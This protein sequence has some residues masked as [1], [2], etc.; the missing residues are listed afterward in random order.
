MSNTID[1]K[2]LPDTPPATGP[3]PG[4][5]YFQVNHAVVRVAKTSDK[6]YLNVRYKLWNKDKQ[7]AGF[8]FDRFFT[9]SAPAPLFK[10]SR[11]I[12]A[13]GIDPE[14]INDFED[15]ALVCVNREGIVDLHHKVSNYSGAPETQVQ[16][17]NSQIFWKLDEAREVFG[18]ETG[19][20]ED[21]DEDESLPFDLFSSDDD[22]EEE[23]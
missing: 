12:R 19:T 1:F 4:Q 17:F 3:A 6:P 5:Y 9:T 8:I 11:F 2:N 13:I 14:E 22:E 20:F 7:P 16:I 10:L 15:L 18:A 21:E 23:E